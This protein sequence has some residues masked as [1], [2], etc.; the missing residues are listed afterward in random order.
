[1]CPDRARGFG[2]VA[3]IVILVILAG[4]A[5]FLANLSA[6]QQI[7]SALDVQG[8]RAKAAAES[9]IE[10]GAYHALKGGATQC[11]ASGAPDV[12]IGDIDG[13]RVT[14][15]CT[16][17]AG[18]GTVEAGLGAIYRIVATAC[19]VPGA[20][21]TCPGNAGHVNYV[22]RRVVALVEQ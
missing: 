17:L 1:M 2:V 19:N 6:T 18:G 22:E 8:A 11:A 20:A 9:G 10:W 15:T 12:D 21:G 7:G 5:G 14:V 3:A 4:L 13:I 16:L